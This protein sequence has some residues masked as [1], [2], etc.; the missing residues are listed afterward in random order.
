[1]IS[2]KKVIYLKTNKIC[3]NGDIIQKWIDIAN[4]L[5]CDYYIVNDNPELLDIF[6]GLTDFKPTEILESNRNTYCEKVFSTFACKWY[7]TTFAHLTTFQ[8]AKKHNINSF[9]NID[10][11]DIE[12]MLPVEQCVENLKN[13]QNYADENNG[14]AYSLDIWNIML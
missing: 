7:K 12:I 2:A 4:N 6:K 10:A 3:E 11:D 9:W 13:I 8:H 14:N 1:M 5:N